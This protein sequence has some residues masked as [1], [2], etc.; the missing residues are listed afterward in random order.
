MTPELKDR[1]EQFVD[2]LET[3]YGNL[4]GV[5]I[6]LEHQ[7]VDGQTQEIATIKQLVI[8]HITKTEIKIK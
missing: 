5:E 2:Q 4:E 1:L 8:Y 3:E 7:I 6:K